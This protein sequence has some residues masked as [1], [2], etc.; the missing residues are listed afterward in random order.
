MK[1]KL[2]DFVPFSTILSRLAQIYS[3]FSKNVQIGASLYGIII[4]CGQS[5][6]V[7]QLTIALTFRYGLF[8][9]FVFGISKLGCFLKQKKIYYFHKNVIA[10][11]VEGGVYEMRNLGC[12]LKPKKIFSA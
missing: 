4:M 7:R 11:L 5:C 3:M 1:E 9:L 6:N 8:S 12:F 2:L 10:Y